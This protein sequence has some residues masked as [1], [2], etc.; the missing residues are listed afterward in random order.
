MELFLA[1]GLILLADW[2]K[3]GQALKLDNDS[4]V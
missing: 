1:L 2:A 4:I 3:D